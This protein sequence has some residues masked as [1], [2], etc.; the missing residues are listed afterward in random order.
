[1]QLQHKNLNKLE[2]AFR[3]IIRTLMILKRAI[4]FIFIKMTPLPL[5]MK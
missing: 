2:F 3:I 5:S 1:M 4:S